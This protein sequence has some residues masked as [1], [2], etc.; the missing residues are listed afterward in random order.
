MR[1]DT[2]KDVK[3]AVRE[4]YPIEH[5]RQHEPMIPQ[6]SLTTSLMN[7]TKPNEPL[8]RVLNPFFVYGPAVIEHCLLLEGLQPNAK[9]PQQFDPTDAEVMGKLMQALQRCE[10]MMKDAQQGNIK[11]VDPNPRSHILTF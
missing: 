8:K 4:T 6:D 9:V 3:Y 10:V 5:A 7:L 11:G 1:A 2:D